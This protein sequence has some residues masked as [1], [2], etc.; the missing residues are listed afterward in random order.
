MGIRKLFGK[1]Y[2]VNILG[3]VSH[4]V[5]VATTHH[6]HCSVKADTENMLTNEFAVINNTLVTKS[7][8]KVDWAAGHSSPTLDLFNS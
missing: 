3:F 1:N 4:K 8:S 5:F 6:F 7:G 2:T